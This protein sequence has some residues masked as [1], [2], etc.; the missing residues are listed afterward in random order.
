VEEV[1][2][3]EKVDIIISEPMGFLLVH[4]RM[5]EVFVLAR[6]RWLKPGGRMFP[7]TGT[8]FLA[9][10]ADEALYNEQ[11]A[12][13]S[14]WQQG[15]FYGIDLTS[16]API[17]M[18][19]HFAQPVV[20]YFDPSILL[21]SVPYASHTINFGST[22]LEAFKRIVIPFSFCITRTAL[23]HGIACW[24]DV[25][26]AGSSATLRLSTSPDAPGTHWYQCRLL[27][28]RPVAVNATQV[29]SGAL[30]MEANERLSYSLTLTVNLDGTSISCSNR[31]ELHDQLYH[32]MSQR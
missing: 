18:Q 6:A 29:I 19:Q 1:E 28:P 23:M 27:L 30:V 20:G 8:I 5:L 11:L 2:L 13:V 4:E 7:S 32:Y 10:F 15:S 12:K 24:F 22:T 17:A 3:P 31:I 14:F 21:A 16:V 26:F 9:P 25:V